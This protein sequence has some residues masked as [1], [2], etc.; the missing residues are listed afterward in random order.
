MSD[1]FYVVSVHHT[2]KRNKFILFWRPKDAGYTF[3]LSQECL[4]S[5]TGAGQYDRERIESHLGH[6][7]DG[8]SNIAVPV[9]AALAL[10]RMTTDAD[11]LD[12]P[13]GLVV[14]NTIANWRALLKAAIAPPKH[15]PRP[16]AIYFGK[17]KKG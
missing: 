6:Y 17:N 15:Q 3:K 7:N 16:E 5:G 1:L 9:E 13:H 12:G 8:E 2:P 11:Q 10:G 4:V 14:H